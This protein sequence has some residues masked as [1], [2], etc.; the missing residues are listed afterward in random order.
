MRGPVLHMSAVPVAALISYLAVLVVCF[1]VRALM[2]RAQTGTTGFRGISG[3]PGSAS[4]WAGISFIAAVLA[5]IAAPLAAVTGLLTT[6]QTLS[7]PAI[8]GTGAVLAGSGSLAVLVAQSGMGASWRVGVDENER[9]TL[10]TGGAFSLVRNPI[11]TAMITAAIGWAL[12]VPTW[13]SLV[14]LATLIVAVELQVRVV[15]E[16][17]LRRAHP[18][19]YPA[20]TARVGRFLPHLKR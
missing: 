15:E 17:Y 1:G 5:G 14:A 20:Y 16:P 3:R 12:M 6:P 4:W 19:Q 2:M 9:T 10:V 13:L 7:G 8:W 11:F 18:Q